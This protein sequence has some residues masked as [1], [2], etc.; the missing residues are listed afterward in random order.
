[1][2]K[3]K[4]TTPKQNNNDEK[5][6][7]KEHITKLFNDTK[8]VIIKDIVTSN[9][10]ISYT[11]FYCTGLCDIE[12][13]DKEIIPELEKVLFNKSSRQLKKNSYLYYFQKVH[14]KSVHQTKI[15]LKR[16]LPDN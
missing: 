14:L 1:M 4:F 16:F 7:T 15:A 5:K 10:E 12:R 8:D 13:I 2:S 3:L 6:F 9:G 11:I